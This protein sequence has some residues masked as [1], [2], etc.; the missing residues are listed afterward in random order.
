MG[1]I[2]KNTIYSN[3]LEDKEKVEKIRVIRTTKF[4]LREFNILN[5]V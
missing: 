4:R 3:N 5:H 2:S 1:V